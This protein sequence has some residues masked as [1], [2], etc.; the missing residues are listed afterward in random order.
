[1]ALKKQ[2]SSQATFSMSSMTDVI[3]LL[4]IFFMV[5]STLINPAAIEVNLPQSSEQTSLKPVTE[6]Y[7]D[8]LYNLYMVENRRDSVAEKKEPRQVSQQELVA[9]LTLIQQQDSLRA[10][11]L[12]A[13]TKVEYGKVIEILDMAARSNL[14]MVLATKPSQQLPQTEQS[15]LVDVPVVESPA[16]N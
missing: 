14:K 9:A 8:S 11:A 12:Y 6:V 2:Y 3:F 16:A 1:M 15:T 7:M 13:D 5:T 10:V 4:L